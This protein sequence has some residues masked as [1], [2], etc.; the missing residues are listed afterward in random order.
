[1]LPLS[2][3]SFLSTSAALTTGAALAGS[4]AAR[5]IEPIARNGQAKFKLSLAAYSY[6]E[7][8]SG[9]MPKL[10]LPSPSTLTQ[11]CCSPLNQK[12]IHHL[13]ISMLQKLSKPKI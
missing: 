4:P 12:A 9:A 10:S 3:R 13:L 5:A 11:E 6:R 2:R 8:L 1:M 7:L